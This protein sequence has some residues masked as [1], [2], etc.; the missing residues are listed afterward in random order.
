MKK[1]H[2]VFPALVLAVAG[3]VAVDEEIRTAYSGHVPSPSA[4]A[5]EGSAEEAPHVGAWTPE[6]LAL[7]AG[8]RSQAMQEGAFDAM[9]ERLKA[10]A[11]TA[12]KDPEFRY[13]GSWSDGDGYDGSQTI[14]ESSV[15]NGSKRSSG[16]GHKFAARVYI[17]NPFINLYLSRRGDAR[18]RRCEA[19]AETAAF[20]VYS[21]VRLLCNED[22]RLARELK[23]LEDRAK[24]LE[25]AHDIAVSETTN[26]VARSPYELIRS[27]SQL[28]RNRARRAAVEFGR[29]KVR[30]NIA[31]LADVPLEGLEIADVPF[32]PPSDA[33]LSEDRLVELAFARRPD[34][35]RAVAEYDVAIAEAGAARAANIP[36]FRFVEAGYRFQ[37]GHDSSFTRR[38]NGDRYS[39]GGDNDHDFSVEVAITVPL[40]TWCGGSVRATNRLRDLADA[41]VRSLRASIR[42]EI[43]DALARYRYALTAVDAD[44]ASFVDEMSRRIDGNTEGGSETADSCKAR[45]ELADYAVF[46]SE[47]EA[48]RDEALVNLETVIGG[49]VR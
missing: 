39:F 13:T 11:D 2:R 6:E 26:H 12:W 30:S 37:D 25:K 22:R 4:V 32:E 5:S 36:W 23:G 21:E 35:A 14:G 18:V 20:A 24:A 28:R 48:L 9:I 15:E 41:R 19:Q 1:F 42:R 34:L 47:A 17:P 33:L 31:V 3:C 8:L 43:S 46:A 7:R 49:P 10:D 29:R 16:S 27:E 45:A 44:S 38:Q 40:F